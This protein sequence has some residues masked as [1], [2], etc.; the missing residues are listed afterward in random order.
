MLRRP[1]MLALSCAA[2]FTSNAFAQSKVLRI[3][4]PYPPGGSPDSTAR[5]I[6]E[7]LQQSGKYTVVVDNKPGAGGSI[8]AETVKSAQPE[9]LTLLLGDSSTYSIAPN[10]KRKLPYD[11]VKDFKP[12][13]LAATS[14]I[15]IVARPQ[16][17]GSVRELI[18]YLKKNPG[19]PYGS[20]G[21]GTA[22]H[23]AMEMLRSMAG[24]EMTHVPYK[25]ASQT[26]PA[27]AAGDVVTAF[28]GLT[29]ANAFVQSGKVKVLAIA[30]P[31][32]SAM[33]SDV[34][35]LAESGLPNYSVVISLG[36]LS[37]TKTSDAAVAELNADISKAVE[38]PDVKSRLNALGVEPKSS[39]PQKFAEQ[40]AAEIKSFGQIARSANIQED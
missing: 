16:V 25:G 30:E 37:N 10:V 18:D 32:R 28:A 8:A 14:P 21:Y 12:V 17:A 23:L 24:L 5:V 20:S 11:P 26:V 29:L 35:T 40:I 3:V 6:G 22:H 1:L 4:V 31:H 7:K 19:Q 39:S 36:F 38:S 34:P 9:T 33:A 27:V 15:V 13:A 2:L